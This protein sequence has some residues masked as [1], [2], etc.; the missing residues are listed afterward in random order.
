MPYSIDEIEDA[1]VI[2]VI[3]S[4]TTE[5]HPLIGRRILRAVIEKGAKLIV[6][7]P[8]SID[9]AD[10]AEI[11][12]QHKPGTDVALINGMMNVILSENLQDTAFIEQRTKNFEAVKEVIQKYP[13]DYVES[14]TGI[15][16]Q[17]VIETAR[18]YAKADRASIIYCMGIT[19][20]TT[21]TDNVV[22]LANLAMM[23]GN[24]GKRSTGVN[25]LRGQNNVQGACDM[26]ALPNFLTGYQRVTEPEAREKME[27]A[28]NVTG[29]DDKVG[30]TMPEMIELAYTDKLKGL[31]IVGENPML[32]EPDIN[33]VREALKKLR[34][35][36]VQDLFLSETAKLA[37]VVLPAASFAEKDGTFTSTDLTV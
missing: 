12:I 20:H 34:F 13:P 37:N 26:G 14:I 32:S 17:K 8:R 19:Q 25:P 18:L 33:H 15:P 22:S 29:L 16:A 28:W 11:Y 27:K 2:F 6:A 4:N 1:E 35:L 24:V 3:G 23:T 7:D 36:V 30:L 21:G 5:Q 31:Y 10:F 9:L